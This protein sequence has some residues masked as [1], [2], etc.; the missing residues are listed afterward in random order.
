MSDP[1]SQT[2]TS[3]ACKLDIFLETSHKHFPI[4]MREDDTTAPGHGTVREVNFCESLLLAE[5]KADVKLSYLRGV[6]YDNYSLE[7]EMSKKLP[8]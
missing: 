4:H 8:S 1:S 6:I 3:V 7:D 5:C 2:V